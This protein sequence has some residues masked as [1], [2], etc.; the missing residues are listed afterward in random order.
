MD[1]G[2]IDRFT[3]AGKPVSAEVFEA[4]AGAAADAPSGTLLVLGHG[5]GGNRSNPLLRAF[6]ARLAGQGF[7]TALYN[8][9]YTEAGK[10]PPDRPPVLVAA[11][12]DAARHLLSSRPAERLVLGGKSMGGR[13]AA[14]AVVQGLA[15]RAD[16]PVAGLLFLGYPLHAAGRDDAWERRAETVKKLSLPSLFLQGSEDRLCRPDLLARAAAGLPAEVHTV[17]GADH[18]LALPKR[19]GRTPDDVLDELTETAVAWLAG[20]AASTSAATGVG[21]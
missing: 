1:G 16:L 18:S 14:E 19:A 8:F 10:K 21:S 4:E 5:A 7:P 9:P 13:I 15:A 20:L 12:V 2:R 17:A 11:A 6:A 3:A